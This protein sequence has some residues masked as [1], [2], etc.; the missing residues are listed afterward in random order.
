MNDSTRQSILS[1][2]SARIYLSFPMAEQSRQTTYLVALAALIEVI[3]RAAYAH[4]LPKVGSILSMWPS[5]RAFVRL[6][7]P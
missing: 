3:P 5:R 2:E 1:R 6:H 7:V 4:E